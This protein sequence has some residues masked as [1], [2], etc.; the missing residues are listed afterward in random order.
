MT[1][2]PSIK[3]PR[4]MSVVGLEHRGAQ[5]AHPS[6]GA[7]HAT[8]E[9]RRGQVAGVAKG[10]GSIGVGPGVET[11]TPFCSIVTAVMLPVPVT[12]QPGKSTGLS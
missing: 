1:G 5:R 9:A 7:A 11:Y 2:G 10:E 3:A 8:F 4:A 6:G 12:P